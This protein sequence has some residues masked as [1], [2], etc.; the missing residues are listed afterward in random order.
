[1]A[2]QAGALYF[3]LLKRSFY[4]DMLGTDIGKA[5]KTREMSVFSG[6]SVSHAVAAGRPLGGG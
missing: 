3:T 1:M 6:V 5:L 2:L 4:Q